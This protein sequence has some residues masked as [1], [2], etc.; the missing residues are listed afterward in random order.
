MTIQQYQ[1]YSFWIQETAK[2]YYLNKD[3][4]ERFEIIKS[5][6]ETKFNFKQSKPMPKKGT[7]KLVKAYLKMCIVKAN[8]NYKKPPRDFI[9]EFLAKKKI[10]LKIVYA[11]NYPNNF[12]LDSSYWH[13][14]QHDDSLR[15]KSK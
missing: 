13:N 8:P 7:L 10:L 9:D 14:Y 11:Q 3:F 1:M 2:Y 5:K 4:N 12:N 6:L 15:Y